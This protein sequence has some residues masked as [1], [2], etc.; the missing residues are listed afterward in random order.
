MSHL[1]YRGVSYEIRDSYAGFAGFYRAIVGTFDG[2]NRQIIDAENFEEMATQ[3]DIYLKSEEQR[4]RD[5]G[6]D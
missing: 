1:N 5:R 6:N 4:L 3:I 2:G